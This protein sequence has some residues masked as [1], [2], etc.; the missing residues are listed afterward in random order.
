MAKHKFVI[1][2]KADVSDDFIKR[3][4][5]E[6]IK[7]YM[8]RYSREEARR[9]VEQNGYFKFIE[10]ELERSIN[11]ALSYLVGDDDFK[12]NIK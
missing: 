11:N 7:Y 1:E 12:M 3:W 5:T 4:E 2:I 10:K 8:R 6:Q 9:I